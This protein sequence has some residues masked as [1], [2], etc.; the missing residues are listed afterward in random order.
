LAVGLVLRRGELV[1][2][3]ALAL[4]VGFLLAMGVTAGASLVFDATGLLSADM[5]SR[6]DQGEFIYDV[7]PFSLIVAILAGSPGC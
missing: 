7:G 5:L 6:L 4:A 2:R 3:G 1:R